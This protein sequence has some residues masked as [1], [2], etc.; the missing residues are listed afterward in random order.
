MKIFKWSNQNRK[1][2][3]CE[4]KH[5]NI[6]KIYPGA[7]RVGVILI[8]F[9]YLPKRIPSSSLLTEPYFIQ[10]LPLLHTVMFH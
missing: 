10:A 5:Q 7:M 3:V 9:C 8:Y 4:E 1:K 6:N 2:K